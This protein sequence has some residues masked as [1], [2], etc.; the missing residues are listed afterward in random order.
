MISLG[1][2]DPDVLEDKLKAYMDRVKKL[3]GLDDDSSVVSQKL[4]GDQNGE[5]IDFAK[6]S[7]SEAMTV[8]QVQQFLKNAGFSPDIDVDG[9]CGYRTTAA[10][11]LFQ[12]YVRSV[13]KDAGIGTPD[14]LLGSKSFGAIQAWQSAGKKANWLSGG[15]FQQSDHHRRGLEFLNSLRDHYLQNPTRMLQMVNAHSDPGDT[16]KVADWRFDPQDIHLVGVRKNAPDTEGKFDDVFF[17]FIRGM[18]FTFFGSTD[19]GHTSNAAGFPFLTFGQHLYRFGW[20]GF[21]NTNR[22]Y[23]ALKPKSRG[24]LV[25]RSKDRVLQDSDLDGG[26]SRN[27]SINVHWGGKG[28]SADIGKWSE[29]CQ[30]IT[31]KGYINH[32]NEIVDC[33][34][35]AALNYS[36]LGKDQASGQYRTKGAY[37]VLADIVTALSAKDN[38]MHYMLL[39]EEDLQMSPEVTGMIE[40][41]RKQFGRIRFA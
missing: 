35:F 29:G 26:L 33:A 39:K 14:G 36:Q 23:Q 30:V 19:P 34:K 22:I 18:V 4:R 16:L 20:H 3:T 8:T 24:V 32:N 37:T 40:A 11:R 9:I 28:F 41:A 17:L 27:A 12:E 7:D 1:M 21:S 38:V 13:D 25:V 6:V 2:F 5:W 31:G 10:I 15:G